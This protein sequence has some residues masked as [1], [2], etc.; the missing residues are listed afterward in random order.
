MKNSIILAGRG[1]KLLKFDPKKD[2][3]WIEIGD[4]RDYNI[5]QISR[6]AISDDGK[7][8]IVGG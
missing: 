8:A 4:F 7:L 3:D 2:N 5:T 6:L 1:T